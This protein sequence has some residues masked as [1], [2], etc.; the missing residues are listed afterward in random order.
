M[1]V[2]TV[3][4]AVCW[5]FLTSAVVSVLFGFVPDWLHLLDR[6][7]GEYE[8]SALPD[9]LD[10]STSN[11]T[12]RG[13]E[14]QTSLSMTEMLKSLSSGA[15]TD[16]TTY[17]PVSAPGWTGATPI[18]VLLKTKGYK[19]VPAGAVSLEGIFENRISEGLDDSIAEEYASKGVPLHER[20]LVFVPN[21]ERRQWPFWVVGLTFLF[22]CLGSVAI[23]SDG[24][25]KA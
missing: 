9:A 3:L 14:V 4:G 18:P 5:P 15:V 22:S 1:R 19:G 21:E 10:A 24:R 2:K 23:A 7:V 12:L 17:T 25:T 13:F 8:L 16:T 20:V 11:A 6:G